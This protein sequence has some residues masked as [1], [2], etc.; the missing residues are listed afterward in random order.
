[1]EITQI[2]VS[3]IPYHLIATV[4]ITLSGVLIIVSYYLSQQMNQHIAWAR[5]WQWLTLS[6]AFLDVIDTVLLLFQ[7]DEMDTKMINRIHQEREL[8][9]I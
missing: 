1:M 9:D 6:F 7:F 8:I 5:V 2:H 4:E 3:T